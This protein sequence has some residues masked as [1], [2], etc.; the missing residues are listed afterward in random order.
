MKCKNKK[1]IIIDIQLKTFGAS[2]H[3]VIIDI[4]AS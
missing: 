2:F 4:P 1:A 3:G